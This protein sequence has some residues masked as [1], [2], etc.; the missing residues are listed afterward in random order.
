MA[1]VGNEIKYCEKHLRNNTI[2]SDNPVRTVAIMIKYLFL[3]KKLEGMDL[4]LTLLEYMDSVGCK[5]DNGFLDGLIKTNTSE[6]TAINSLDKITITTTEWETIQELG[7]NERERK[8]LFYI[9]CCYK[10]KVG[11]GFP[12]N[13]LVKVEYTKL[14]KQA[15]VTL[16]KDYRVDMFRYFIETGL[17]GMHVGKNADKLTIN[18]VADGKTLIEITEFD[19]IDTYYKHIKKGNTKLIFCEGCGDL[20]SVSGNART[21]YCKDCA[22]KKEQERKNEQKRIERAK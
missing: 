18:Y 21:K 7:R 13:R 4:K 2:D 9:L 22:K 8:V 19:C 15:H 14:N 11:L 17:V 1:L 16:T 12:D 10:I 3:V 20:V 5:L 6:K